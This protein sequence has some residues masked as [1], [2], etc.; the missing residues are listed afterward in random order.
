MNGEVADKADEAIR[1]FFSWWES[2]RKDIEHAYGFSRERWTAYKDPEPTR[3]MVDPVIQKRVDAISE[4]IFWEIGRDDRRRRFTFSL[5]G[6]SDPEKVALCE[7]WEASAPTDNNGWLFHGRSLPDT[8]RDF[9]HEGV[10]I[11]AEAF[12][13]TSELNPET[14]RLDVRMGHPAFG[15]L[16]P[17]GQA[18]V[19]V[20]AI[21]RFLGGAKAN[22]HVASLVCDAALENGD[23]MDSL[24]AQVRKAFLHSD[25]QRAFSEFFEVWNDASLLEDVKRRSWRMSQW[26]QRVS[27]WLDGPPFEFQVRDGFFYIVTGADPKAAELARR[28]V[29]SGGAN[30]KRFRIAEAFHYEH[31]A[32]VD[33]AI[34]AFAAFWAEDGGR[35]FDDESV[36]ATFH[37]H[38]KAIRLSAY[39]ASERVVVL[40]DDGEPAQRALGWRLVARVKEDTGRTHPFH[41]AATVKDFYY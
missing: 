14:L 34:E 1:A 18:R 8:L 16:D 4:C 27:G 5:S 33:D 3:E 21:H 32:E 29:A 30:A 28:L 35:L 17:I 36:Q 19:A 38:M 7:R 26:L 13:V 12:R 41:A 40:L 39:I 25:A 11:R 6:F 22:A 20:F 2:A 9:D 24:T 23:P 31:E 37:A 15:K 10:L